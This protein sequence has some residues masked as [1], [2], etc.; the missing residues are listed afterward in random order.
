M[1]TETQAPKQIFKA[2]IGFQQEVQKIIKDK[3]NPFHK[4]KYADLS[5]IVEAVKPALNM[6]GLAIIQP[7]KT[8]NLVQNNVHFSQMVIETQMIHSSGEMITSEIYV[9]NHPDP[10][11]LGSLITYYR[12]YTYLSMIGLAPQADDDDGNNASNK[13]NR[14]SHDNQSNNQNSTKGNSQE[15]ANQGNTQSGQVYK[16]SANQI[17]AIKKIYGPDYKIKEDLTSKEA[18]ELISKKN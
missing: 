15:S 16:A 8:I 5:N 6:N 12:R 13:T 2:I 7:I 17:N 9:P 10:Q 3:E 11:K 18:S 1:E 4:S 14:G